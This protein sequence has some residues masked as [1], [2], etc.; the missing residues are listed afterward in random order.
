MTEKL[1]L[2][3]FIKLP[4]EERRKLLTEQANDPELIKYYQ[5]LESDK[6]ALEDKG[7]RE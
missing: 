5:A 1:T 6:I 3:E 2:K 4:M 7:M